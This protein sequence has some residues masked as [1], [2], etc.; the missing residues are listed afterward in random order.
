MMDAFSTPISLV[1]NSRQVSSSRSGSRVL[2]RAWL[3]PLRVS[4]SRRCFSREA[5][6]VSRLSWAEVT[7][8][9]SRPLSARSSVLA[10]HRW[11]RTWELCSRS[12]RL[13]RV[14]A[15]VWRKS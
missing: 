7:S 5:L 4:S 10:L 12:L 2:V 13:R 14:R 15:T 3:T 1:T 11:V 8:C 9:S 6:M